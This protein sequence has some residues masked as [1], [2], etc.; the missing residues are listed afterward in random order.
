[1]ATWDVFHSDRLEVERGLDDA[2]VR[3]ALAKGTLTE[4]DL[5]RPAGSGA[6]WERLGDRP[7]LLPTAAPKQPPA[8]PP[9]PPTPPPPPKSVW[10]ADTKKKYE[11][12]IPA[13]PV[14]GGPDFEKVDPEDSEPSLFAIIDDDDDADAASIEILDAPR[15]G[16]VKPPPPPPKAAPKYPPARS[17]S[18]GPILPPL[19][20][21][22]AVPVPGPA[23]LPFDEVVLEAEF[24]DEDEYDPLEEDEE[25]AEFTLS[26][27]SAETVEELDLAAMVDVAFQL[28]LFFLVTA[29]TVFYK[30]LEVPKPNNDAP[31]E[32]ATQAR[33]KSL[34]DLKSDFILV[35]I[36]PGGTLKIDRQPVPGDLTMAALA[37]QLRKLREDTGRKA[38]LLSA[39]FSTPHRLAVLAYDAA[40]EIGMG[41]AIARPTGNAPAPPPAVKKG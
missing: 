40:N 1:L 19:D 3:K 27:R 41:I 16:G 20:K 39:D 12:A 23:P 30:S 6:P 13:D 35:E 29:T 9:P 21:S 34:D 14:V 8:A 32:A 28:V 4:D 22:T 2:G 38:M 11:W 7:D 18:T 33:S 5:I 25:A 26:R 37:E 36:D 17:V 10:E 31:P 24:D 15:P